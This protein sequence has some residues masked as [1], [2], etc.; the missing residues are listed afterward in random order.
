MITG[1]DAVACQVG[2]CKVP[3]CKFND[4]LMCTAA[5]ITVGHDGEVVD[6]LS[7]VKA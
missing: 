1:I 2:A 7:Y 4:H 5:G 3:N 6:C